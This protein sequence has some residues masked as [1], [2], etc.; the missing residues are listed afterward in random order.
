MPAQRGLFAALVSFLVSVAALAATVSAG[1]A[2][3]PVAWPISTGLVLAE[4]V[5]GGASASDEYVEIANGAPT[6]LDL[7]GLEVVYVTASG[8]TVTRKTSFT[9]PLPLA[10]G[11]HFLLANG[12][13]IYGPLADATYSG[14][15]AADGG[16]LALRSTGGSIVDAVGWG[17]AA[18][19]FVEGSAA[20]A[21]PGQVEHRAPPRRRGRQPGRYQRQPGGLADAAEPHSPVAGVRS[22]AGHFGCPPD[23]EWIGLARTDAADHG[24]LRPSRRKRRRPCGPQLQ[25]RRRPRPP[26]LPRR[27]PVPPPP[28][29][30]PTSRPRQLQPVRLFPPVPPLRPVLPCAPSP[31]PGPPV[32]VRS[33]PSKGSSRPD[34]PCSRAAAAVSSRIST[35]GIGIYLS[36]VPVVALSA[37]TQVRVS[38]TLDDRYGQRVIRVS[39]GGLDFSARPRR[40]SL[41]SSPRAASGEVD[42]GLL[43]AVSGIVLDAPDA[44]A[45]GLG[46]SI[47]DG[48]GPLRVVATPTAV[49]ETAIVRG[50]RVMVVG[51]LGQRVSGSSPGYRV[52]VTEPDSI[53]VVAGPSPS[54]PA[55][56]SPSGPSDGSP[57]PTAAPSPSPTEPETALESIAAA[58]AQ[59]A[60]TA[61]HVAGVVTVATGVTGTPE[62]FAVEDSSGGIFVRV[63]AP[64]DGLVPG[65]SIE[66]AGVLA[67]PYGQLEIRGVE[68]LSLGSQDPA[69]APRQV[70]LSEIA[71]PLEGSLVMV[72][73]SV[74]SVRVDSGRLTLSVGDGSVAVR[75][76]ADPP[77]GLTRADVARGDVVAVTGIVG[78]RASATGRA[79]GYRLWL[80]SRSDL[81]VLPA[82]RPP[83]WRRPRLDRR[84]RQSITTWVRR[85]GF[86]AAWSTSTPRS[87]P[88]LASSTWAARPSWSKMGR[89]L[90]PSSCHPAR[91]SR[92]W[93]RDSRSSAGSAAGREVRRSLHRRSFSRAICRPRGRSRCP[94][95][96][97]R[98]WNGGWSE[99]A[100]G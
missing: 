72:R 39:D 6:P 71:E 8:S 16:S 15:L 35:A 98:T 63:T 52:Q 51:P 31:T 42:E 87:R 14:G 22:D 57:G 55:T 75:V 25:H 73:G 41:C 40:P 19:S 53:V 85:L 18:N 78:Q 84:H 70:R 92:A 29:S 94:V 49:G 58:R 23:G 38:G 68:W 2:V 3:T 28:D 45:D 67:A 1:Y 66:L 59:P 82:E 26:L 96:S 95:R 47:D 79:D 64:I 83:S 81:I 88:R 30:Q 37:G 20:P 46:I 65:R 91:T 7:N 13:G 86:E 36:Q 56:A 32:T 97:V 80:R 60:G 48:S 50:T 76:L 44:L 43:V 90:W 33:L 89:R 27:R 21:P 99:C 74:D 12:A 10:P 61:A 24:I 54:A 9:S 93:D 100:A 11:Q 34:W 62:L 77:T 5:T 4:V 17:S 69:P